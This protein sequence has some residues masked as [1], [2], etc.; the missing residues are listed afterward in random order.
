[1][2]LRDQIAVRRV[3]FDAIE[4]RLLRAPRGGDMGRN[5]FANARDRHLLGH[6]GLEC[7]LVDRVWNGRRCDGR[8]AAY[9]R[10]RM[11]AG[12]AELDRSLGAA[13]VDRTNKAV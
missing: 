11:A 3:D 13:A 4:A 2:E 8:L 5:R 10:T 12:V 9:V 7:R 1:M 6:D